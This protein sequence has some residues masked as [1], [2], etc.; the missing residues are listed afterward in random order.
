MKAVYLPITAQVLEVGTT[1]KI[2]LLW[3]EK[4]I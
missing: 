3:F 1:G 2:S 4:Y